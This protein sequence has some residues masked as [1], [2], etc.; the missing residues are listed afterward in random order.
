ML[1]YAEKMLELAGKVLERAGKV[2]V[3]PEP[4]AGKVL[5]HAEKML[6]LAGKVLELVELEPAEPEPTGLEL[7]V[8]RPAVLR[9]AEKLEPA[10]K[11]AVESESAAERS[12]SLMELSLSML[13]R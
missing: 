13:K 5:G 1:E 9:P 7:A 4:S 12:L 11:L 3:E 8:L 6:E 2:P 10:G